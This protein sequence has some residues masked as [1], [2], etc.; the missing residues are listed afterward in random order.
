VLPFTVPHPVERATVLAE[1]TAF[2]ACDPAEPRSACLGDAQAR[3]ACGAAPLLVRTPRIGQDS[4]LR[5]LRLSQAF[6]V[7]GGEDD[8]ARRQRETLFLNGVLWLLRNTCAQRGPTLEADDGV[9]EPRAGTCEILTFRAH[10]SHNAECDETGVLVSA[11][12]PDAFQLCGIGVVSEPPEAAPA[13]FL[14][15]QTVRFDFGLLRNGAHTLEIA[16]RAC[17]AGVF[18]NRFELASANRL[19]VSFEQRIQVEG[20]PCAD[21]TPPVL[22]VLMSGDSLEIRVSQPPGCPARLEVSDD[23]RTWQ[24]V[25]DGASPWVWRLPVANTTGRFYRLSP[26]H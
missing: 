14:E 9:E 17:E 18:T 7:G 25:P 23:L 10:L 5:P 13:V 15:G 12:V 11:F 22:N 19:P 6:L 2:P 20:A 1:A 24:P 4:A 3:L 26:A 8:P 21:C 16:L